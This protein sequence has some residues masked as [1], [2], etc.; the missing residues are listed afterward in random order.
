MPRIKLTIEYEGTGYCGWQFQKDVKTIQGELE[1]AFKVIYKSRVAITGSGRTDSG[2]H[3]RSQIAH[4]DIPDQLGSS[5]D[6]TATLTKLKKSINGIIEKDIVVKEIEICEPEFHA[7]Y[8]AKSRIY[9]YYIST[10]PT[11]LNRSFSWLISYSLDF[12][13]MQKAAN[14]LIQIK[15]FENFCKTGSNN[16][17]TLC[18]VYKSYWKQNG[19]IWIYEIEANRFLRG[20]VRGIVGTL[21]S[22]GNNKI[23]Y[24]EYLEILKNQKK[25]KVTFLAPAKGLFLEQIKY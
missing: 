23:K 4:C 6:W 21:V 25:Q 19:D 18:T 7:R 8:D 2:V 24:D 5:I 14:E 22:L 16:K 11:S 1:R 17:T 10:T 12:A 9:R 15:D 13:M 3:A 20:M